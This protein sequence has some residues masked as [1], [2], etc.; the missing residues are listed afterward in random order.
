MKSNAEQKEDMIGHV[1]CFTRT[2]NCW[3]MMQQLMGHDAAI[4]GSR[5]SK[6]DAV[7]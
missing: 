2:S 1:V 6:Q 5:C 3:V 7:E 4:A